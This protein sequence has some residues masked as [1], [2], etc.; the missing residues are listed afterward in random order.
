MGVR[1]IAAALAWDAGKALRIAVIPSRLA[2]ARA[3][4]AASIETSLSRVALTWAGCPQL[5]V[6]MSQRPKAVGQAKGPQ[7]LVMRIAATIGGR[8]MGC[9][10]CKR[11]EGT[12]DGMPQGVKGS[13]RGATKRYV[14]GVGIRGTFHEQNHR[15][16]WGGGKLVRFR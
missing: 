3:A 8:R 9:G 6:N 10:P 16:G 4:G 1:G 12:G 7:L 13:S 2:R 14:P 15:R 11:R 5:L